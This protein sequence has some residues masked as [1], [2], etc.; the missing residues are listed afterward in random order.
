MRYVCTIASSDVWR[1]GG[2]IDLKIKKSPRYALLV[3]I[4]VH[5]QN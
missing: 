4:R 2:E 1:A 5:P 3:E